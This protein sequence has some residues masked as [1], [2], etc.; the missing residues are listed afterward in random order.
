MAFG[1][2]KCKCG[3]VQLWF[4]DPDTNSHFKTDKEAARRYNQIVIDYGL[5]QPPYKL[6]LNPSPELAWKLAS[7]PC[8]L[9]LAAAIEASPSH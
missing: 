9:S 2:V 5:D 7:G 6:K 8:D 3:Q 4:T 1:A